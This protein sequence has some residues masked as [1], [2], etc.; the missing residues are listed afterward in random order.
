M[1]WILWLVVAWLCFVFVN[2][3]NAQMKRRRDERESQLQEV[4]KRK[5]EAKFESD[6][7][8]R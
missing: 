2:G 8:E 5:K 3:F 4:I 7:E 6:K 1:K